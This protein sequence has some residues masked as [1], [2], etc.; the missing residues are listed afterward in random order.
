MWSRY[1]LTPW[2]SPVSQGQTRQRELNALLSRFF[3]DGEQRGDSWRSYTEGYAPHM[4]SWVTENTLHIKADLPGLE[5]SDVEITVEGNRL[6]L[7]GERKAEQEKQEGQYFHREVRYGSFER[8]FTIPDGVKAEEVQATYRN[9]VLKLTLPLPAAIL[10]KKVTIAVEG[11][12]NGQPQI[13][14]SK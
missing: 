5:P 8:R 1:T 7:R 4:E 3:G 14:A 2:H 9:G 11:Q 10:P 12:T 13:D 6:T